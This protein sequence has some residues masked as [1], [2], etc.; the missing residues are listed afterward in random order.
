[1]ALVLYIY[2]RTV[3]KRSERAR[4]KRIIMRHSRGGEDFIFL[5]R[6][7]AWGRGRGRRGKGEGVR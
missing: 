3:F 6:E 7:Y 5:F 1:M 2:I 4:K